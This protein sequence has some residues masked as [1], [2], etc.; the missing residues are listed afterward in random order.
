MSYSFNVSDKSVGQGLRRIA[1]SQIKAAIEDIDAGGEEAK[2]VHEVRK[3]CKKLRALAR[4]VRTDLPNY[5]QING[6]FRDAAATLSGTRDAQVML[7]T[8]DALADRFGSDF[9]TA[10]FAPVRERLVDKRRQSASAANGL[11]DDLNTFRKTMVRALNDVDS[12]TIKGS[13]IDALEANLA[14]SLKDGTKAL[15]R[16]VKKPSTERMHELRKRVKDH[17]YHMRLL[18]TVWPGPMGARADE[19]SRLSDILGD[20]H[21]LAV[22]D[23]AV[24]SLATGDVADELRSF[25]ARR[26]L[27][28]QTAGLSLAARV[29]AG[30]PKAEAK[31]FA[32]L[33]RAFQSGTEIDDPAEQGRA[34]DTDGGTT[35]IER[36][37]LVA[38]EDWRFGI[39]KTQRIRQGYLLNDERLSLR[40][41]ITDDSQAEITAKS[42]DPQLIRDEITVPVSVATAKRLMNFARGTVLEKERHHVPVG[43]SIVEVDEFIAPRGLRLAEIELKKADQPIPHADWIG[44]EV[45]G[46]PAFYGATLAAAPFSDSQQH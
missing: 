28:L 25:I 2:T 37:F 6:T 38:G 16:T 3:R 10:R 12:W 32:A 19:L 35:E 5:G 44:R 20:E 8:F 18:R 9:D 39:A 14:K 21:D 41:R 29:Y 23:Q 13:G 7:E 4:L 1:R 36:K 22:F 15:A 17:W 31:R 42:A 11:H 27:E 24:D 26:R 46:D 40:V 30:R 33:W 43:T 34:D 45:T